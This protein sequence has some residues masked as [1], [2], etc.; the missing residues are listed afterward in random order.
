M[1]WSVRGD[2]GTSRLRLFRIVGGEVVEQAEGP[3]I[4]VLEGTPDAVLARELARWE[5]H[6]RPDMVTLVGMA[7]ARTG[8]YETPYVACPATSRQ[9]VQAAV[10]IESRGLPIQ[11]AAG[12]HKGCDDIMRG[13]EAQIFGALAVRPELARGKRCFV[14]PGTH[15]KW[16]TV[17]DGT[18][19]SFRTYPSGELFALLG[20]RSTL[21]RAPAAG[22]DGDAEASDGW[23]DGLA[24]AR[25]GAAFLGSLFRSRAAQL[26]EG[27][28]PGWA[29]G[30]VSGM[31]IGTEV[32]EA[33][34]A[35]P[36]SDDP[37]VIGE[38]KLSARYAAALQAFG[39]RP[40]RCDGDVCA[41]TGLELL[42]AAHR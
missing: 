36:A 18:I 29:A 7:G 21:F 24:L 25:S 28:G 20:E 40:S 15:S 35:I 17:V 22:L 14:L 31:L 4:G 19:T 37:V 26:L 33:R 8:L 1:S 34:M 10:I 12:L 3:G 13:E 9:W 39:M 23:H 27:R 16:A 38:S 6:G 41:L 11:I 42:D 32:R 5:S 30:F 2:W